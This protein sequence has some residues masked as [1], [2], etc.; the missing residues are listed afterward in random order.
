MKIFPAQ[1]ATN[2]I[3]A[4]DRNAELPRKGR[5]WFL[6]RYDAP[7]LFF[8]EFGVV[9]VLASWEVSISRMA[10]ESVVDCVPI[11]GAFSNPFQI[12]R[13]VVRLYSVYVVDLASDRSRPVKCLTNQDVNCSGCWPSIF[14]NVHSWVAS[15]RQAYSKRLSES[16]CAR[17]GTNPSVVGNF[18]KTLVSK[19]R[20]PT[21]FGI[22]TCDVITGGV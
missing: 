10:H 14:E 9:I 5:S 12:M 1:S 11:I 13:E 7:R 17:R 15:A 18:I 20:Q 6:A 3:D 19:Y 2:V 4:I 22:H 16:V 21:L 8:G